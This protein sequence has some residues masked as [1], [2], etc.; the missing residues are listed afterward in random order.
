MVWAKT[1]R[2]AKER[3]EKEAFPGPLEL[4][5]S[6]KQ[7]VKHPGG[8]VDATSLALASIAP[9]P[10][11]HRPPQLV[12]NWPGAYR[13][14]CSRTRSGPPRQVAG[15]LPYLIQVDAQ[16]FRNNNRRVAVRQMGFQSS[17]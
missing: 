5:Q 2:K 17:V 10:R 11:L 6:A 1:K 9:W 14:V 8:C 16:V 3:I 7:V 4:L 15:I 13:G 12:Q